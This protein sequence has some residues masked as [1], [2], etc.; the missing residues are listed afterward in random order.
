MLKKA[1]THIQ[2][3][4]KRNLSKSALA[5]EALFIMSVS[6][7][8]SLNERVLLDWSGDLVGRSSNFHRKALLST[9]DLELKQ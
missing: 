6:F 4:E 9:K 8:G 5:H 1:L 2:T 7:L 3:T